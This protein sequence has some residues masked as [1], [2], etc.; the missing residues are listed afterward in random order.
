MADFVQNFKIIVAMK[1]EKD[2]KLGPV[3]CS[4]YIQDKVKTTVLPQSEG[5]FFDIK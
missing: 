1:G 3:K 4:I 2:F 5:Q